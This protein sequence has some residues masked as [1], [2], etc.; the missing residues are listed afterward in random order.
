MQEVHAELRQWLSA[1][2]SPQAA[3]ETRIL[4]GGSGAR[5]G[6]VCV[7]GVRA[8]ARGRSAG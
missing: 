2:V 3:E 5:W 1:N 8:C 7:E 4:Y 6:V